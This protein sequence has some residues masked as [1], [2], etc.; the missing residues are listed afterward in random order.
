MG[1]DGDAQCITDFGDVLE[2]VPVGVGEDDEADVKVGDGADESAGL[3]TGVDEDGVT[4]AERV[5]GEAVGVE[6]SEDHA[7]DD[8]TVAVVGNLDVG[9]APAV[10]LG[11][12]PL[13]S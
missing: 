11:H 3:V 6:R 5:K 10:S 13:P 2:V 7:A 1:G 9:Q 12:L 4:A 8:D